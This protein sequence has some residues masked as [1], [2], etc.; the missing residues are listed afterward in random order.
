MR[1]VKRPIWIGSQVKAFSLIGRIV[2]IRF[3]GRL[4]LPL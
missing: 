2:S 1:F 3:A 4:E